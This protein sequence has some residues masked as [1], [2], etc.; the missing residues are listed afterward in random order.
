MLR[1]HPSV[2]R[3]FRQL[4]TSQTS[5]LLVNGEPYRTVW[6][7][8]TNDAEDSYKVSMIEQRPVTLAT[9]TLLENADGVLRPHRCSLGAAPCCL[10]FMLTRAM[11]MPALFH[12]Q[13]PHSFVVVEFD[14]Y[15]DT[16]AA[17]KDMVVRG[18]RKRRAFASPA[19]S[20]LCC[21]ARSHLVAKS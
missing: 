18:V 17:I 3:C 21:A 6:Y 2:L 1:T 20:G 8:E 12:R 14:N 5:R 9:E 15:V 7:N 10:L 4:H 11:L 16:A 13:L 19:A